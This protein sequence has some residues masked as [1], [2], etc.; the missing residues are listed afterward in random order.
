M[1]R[2]T[3]KPEDI[4]ILTLLRGGPLTGKELRHQLAEQMVEYAH[5]TFS[6]AMQRLRK[7]GLVEVEEIERGPKGGSPQKRYTRTKAGRHEWET[8]MAFYEMQAAIAGR[9]ILSPPNAGAI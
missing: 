5:G 1:T 9:L 7:L 6:K 4:R 3:L 8:A 2:V